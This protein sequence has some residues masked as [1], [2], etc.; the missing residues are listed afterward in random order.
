M[1]VCICG[2]LLIV[3]AFMK[4]RAPSERDV[5]MSIESCYSHVPV[6]TATRFFGS[7]TARRPRYLV[8]LHHHPAPLKVQTGAAGGYLHVF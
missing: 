2:Y 7:N 8:L 5:D 6:L 1:L 3:A 4:N